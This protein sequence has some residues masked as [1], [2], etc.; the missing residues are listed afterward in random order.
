MDKGRNTG[1]LE[2]FMGVIEGTANRSER[3]RDTGSSMD[4]DPNTAHEVPMMPT[5][6]PNLLQ[7]SSLG[8]DLDL[9]F[10]GKTQM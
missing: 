3:G 2:E 6:K 5:C 10:K 9:Y 8:L 4:F 1:S 7:L